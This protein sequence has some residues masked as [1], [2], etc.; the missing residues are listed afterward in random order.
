M[1]F[2]GQWTIGFKHRLLMS[3]YVHNI[4]LHCTDGN[5]SINLMVENDVVICVAGKELMNDVEVYKDGMNSL[6]QSH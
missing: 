3:Q 1:V 2:K 4:L 6:T 5:R